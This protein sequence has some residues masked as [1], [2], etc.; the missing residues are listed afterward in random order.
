MKAASK[1]WYET[2]EWYSLPPEVSENLRWYE[3]TFLKE[4]TP[5]K[6]KKVLNIGCGRNIFLKKLKELGCRVI[7]M[8]INE[9]IIEFTKNV[10]GIEDVHTYDVLDFARNYKGKKFDTIIFF[11]VLEHLES[12]K[13]FIENLKGILEEDGDIVFSVPSRQRIMPSK[14][15]W[16][17]PP[18]HLTRW[19]IGSTK[20]FLEINGYHVEIIYLSPLSAEDLLSV[21]RV[22]FGTKYL[23]DKITKGDKRLLVT[24]TFK[25]LFKFRVVFYNM[26]AI[27]FRFLIKSQ[28]LNI[29]AV[30]RVK[31]R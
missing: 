30:A 17:Y 7:A 11:E 1:E 29:Y 21:F 4:F 18:H 22:Y 27:I 15:M 12:P 10:L 16:D 31:N 26:L 20:K 6:D 28:G 14:D 2:S 8:D 25:I 5:C 24:Q 3:I 19:N 9:K 23:E 13:E